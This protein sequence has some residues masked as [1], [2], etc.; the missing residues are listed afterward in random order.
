MNILEEVS[1]NRVNYAM[2]IIGGVRRDISIEQKE[3]IKYLLNEVLEEHKKITEIFSKDKITELRNKGVGILTKEDAII[4]GACGPHG[5]ASGM[6]DDVRKLDPYCSYEDFN[7]R[8]IVE[9]DCDVFSRVVVRILE[10]NESIK[11]IKQ[12]LDN[13]PDTEINLGIKFIKILEGEY[14]SRIEAP[15]GEVTYYVVLNGGQTNVRVNIHVSTFKNA[16]TIPKMLK[17]NTISDAG[18]IVASIDPCFSCLDRWYYAWII[19]YTKYIKYLFVRKKRNFKFIKEINLCVGEF[20]ELVPNC[21]NYYFEIISKGTVEENAKINIKKINAKIKC[22]DC[23]Y[24]GEIN[25]D[26]IWPLCSSLNLKILGGNEFYLESLEV[27]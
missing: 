13:L 17:E 7:F 12:A 27:D 11:I 9:T 20:C 16:A 2:N 21:I 19:R 23:L 8:N 14:L 5:R 22:L 26:Y 18:L 3:N 6:K 1:G 15:R 24:E 4:Y 25:K 10:I